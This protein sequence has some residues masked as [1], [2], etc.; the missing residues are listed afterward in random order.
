MKNEYETFI[1][2]C[3]VLL[4]VMVLLYTLVDMYNIKSSVAMG[5][6]ACVGIIWM[7]WICSV[8]QNRD[9]I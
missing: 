9:T 7:G 3:I 1:L 8:D 5:F 6:G 4:I 2:K